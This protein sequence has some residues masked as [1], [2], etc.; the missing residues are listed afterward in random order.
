MISTRPPTTR[1]S[2]LRDERGMEIQN[3]GYPYSICESLAQIC[4]EGC[5]LKRKVTFNES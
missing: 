5:F 1:T 2:S 3:V 4:H